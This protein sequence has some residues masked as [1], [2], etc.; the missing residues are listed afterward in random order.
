MNF[1][2][3]V[4]KLC[5]FIILILLGSTCPN[6]SEASELDDFYEQMQ[7]LTER[8]RVI[9]E[10]IAN[11]DTPK[12]KPKDLKRK[13]K[14]EEIVRLKRTNPMH[15]DVDESAGKFEMMDSTIEEIKPNGNAVNLDRELFNKGNNALDLQQSTNLY[16]KTK[17]LMKYAIEGAK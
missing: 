5:Q 11:A 12:Y 17:N 10:N 4:L 16:N 13:T 14:N 1:G 8:D 7:F 15:F 6:F 3:F 9:S 2:A